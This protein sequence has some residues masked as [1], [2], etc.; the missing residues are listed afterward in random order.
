MSKD[1]AVLEDAPAP[2]LTPDMVS[3]IKREDMEQAVFERFRRSN[4]GARRT[5]SKPAKRSPN[6]QRMDDQC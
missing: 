2:A 1:S 5:A 6:W 4:P 3:K